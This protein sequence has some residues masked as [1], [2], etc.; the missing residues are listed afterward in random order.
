MLLPSRPTGWPGRRRQTRCSELVEELFP[1]QSP[2]GFD[3]RLDR[4]VA[5]LS[6]DIIDDYP[7]ADPRWAEALPHGERRGAGSNPGNGKY[8][9]WCVRV[10]WK[11]CVARCLLFMVLCDALFYPAACAPVQLCYWVSSLCWN[12]HCLKKEMA[13]LSSFNSYICG[14]IPYWYSH[15]LVPR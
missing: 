7:A 14:T 4:T 12:M 15:K 6:A 3:S 10:V 11:V 13:N 8:F 2:A 9:W 1:R 5:E